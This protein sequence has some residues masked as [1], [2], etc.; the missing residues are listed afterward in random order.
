MGVRVSFVDLR[1]QQDCPHALHIPVRLMADSQTHRAEF[2]SITD[3]NRNWVIQ[4]TKRRVATLKDVFNKVTF[5]KLLLLLKN[6]NEGWKL[7]ASTPKPHTQLKVLRLVFWA[8]HMMTSSNGNIF[9]VTG[10]LCGEFTGDRWI[11]LT[12][13]SDAELW[14]FL[15]LRPNKRLSKQLWGWWFETSSCPLWRH[16]N[17]KQGNQMYAFLNTF[18]TQCE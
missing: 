15:D 5:G 1:S 10:H 7:V 13:A 12:K 16:C 17:E 6:Y 2:R 14:C 9:R 4:T 3:R 8:L 11:P 18:W